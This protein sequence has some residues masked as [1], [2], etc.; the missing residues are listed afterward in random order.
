MLWSCSSYYSVPSIPHYIL[1][2]HLALSVCL[3]GPDAID[4][5][6]SLAFSFHPHPHLP[7][8]TCPLRVLRALV[9]VGPSLRFCTPASMPDAR[10]AELP[11]FPEDSGA[12]P[13]RGAASRTVSVLRAARLRLAILL[14]DEAHGRDVPSLQYSAGGVRRIWHCPLAPRARC[15]P[16]RIPFSAMR[17]LHTHDLF[18][19]YT[20]DTIAS[21]SL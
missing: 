15:S 20:N 5:G 12:T 19:A 7:A 4:V 18:V 16:R 21:A 10:S 9:A 8:S 3:Y 17:L 6:G 11:L 1:A 13:P 2:V 14:T